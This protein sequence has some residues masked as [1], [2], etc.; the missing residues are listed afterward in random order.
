MSFVVRSSQLGSCAVML[1]SA[2]L[3]GCVGT[4]LGDS[5]AEPLAFRSTAGV[6]L[7]SSDESD[8][9]LISDGSRAVPL[10]L[11]R[12]EKRRLAT[13]EEH[14]R[15]MEMRSELYAEE[16][17][18][19]IPES[20]SVTERS[21]AAAR[22]L[23]PTQLMELG[24]ELDEPHF[25]FKRLQD[26][27]DATRDGLVAERRAQLGGSQ[28]AL[29]A[30]VHA[31]GGEVLARMWLVNVVDVHLPAGRVPD[32]VLWPGV[33]AISINETTGG[34]SN[35]RGWNGRELRAGLLLDGAG[36]SGGDVDFYSGCFSSPTDPDACH[37]ANENSNN[38]TGEEQRIANIEFDDIAGAICRNHVG[39]L[40]GVPPNRWTEFSLVRRPLQSRSVLS[41]SG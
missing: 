32:V 12:S 5:D 23:P 19:R 25:E 7:T 11:D 15:I 1:V 38:G 18:A 30:R 13:P 21:L 16:K 22:A 9:Y 35:H 33:Q 14:Q 31:V 4:P 40:D 27:D 8:E 10:S 39:W 20:P 41:C 34:P 17:Q 26:V 24:I 6:Q 3:G 2:A 36:L 29:E 37:D 28:D